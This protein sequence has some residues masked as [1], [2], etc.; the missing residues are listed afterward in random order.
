[1]AYL[2]PVRLES[3]PRVSD[4][5]DR[6]LWYVL[7]LAVAALAWFALKGLARRGQLVGLYDALDPRV[8]ALRAWVARAP[9]VFTYIA[10]WTATSVVQQ[11]QPERI[12]DL[13][14]ILSSTNITNLLDEPLR[15]L[16]ASALLVA[17]HAIGFLFYVVV[18]ALIAA[19]LEHR[20]GSA[21]WVAV[22]AASHVLGTLLTVQAERWGLARDV[23]PT[24]I[25]VSQDIGV[26]YVMVGSLGAYLW[27]VGRP[28]RT[29]YTVALGLGILGP[30]LVWRTIWDL[31]HLLA[32]LVG[33]AAGWVALRWPTR[34]RLVWRDLVGAAS[35]R[36]LPTFATHPTGAPVAWARSDDQHGG[37]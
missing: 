35:P 12:S 8:Q 34:D 27:L 33:V 1:M 29:P 2:V 16:V 36:P 37:A 11:G 26:S 3:D 15:V 14:A 10:I 9:A 21:R 31:G 28:W 19:R 25:V 32:T 6:V 4:L 20:I 30:L 7:A 13:V 23:I 17:D 22:A 24:S 18:Y 5:P